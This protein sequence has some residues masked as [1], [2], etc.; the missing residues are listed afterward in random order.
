MIDIYSRGIRWPL[1]QL[2]PPLAGFFVCGIVVDY[3]QTTQKGQLE[4][5]LFKT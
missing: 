3:L 5:V 2:A 1:V 4:S